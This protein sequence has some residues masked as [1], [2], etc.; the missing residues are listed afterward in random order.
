MSD[1]RRFLVSV[2]VYAGT[3][4]VATAIPVFL[5]PLLTR[6]L[7]PEDYGM[8]GMFLI[9][10]NFATALVGLGLNG[11]LSVRY[12]QE[13]FDFVS[14]VKGCVYLT[15]LMW[16]VMSTL[17]L[18]GAGLVADA[19]NMPSGWVLLAVT[20]GASNALL[21]LRLAI[22]QAA[23][24]P[25]PF[26]LTR[27]AQAALD[28]SMSLLMVL[29]IWQAWQGRVMGIAGALIVIGGFATFSLWR[30]GY[31]RAPT[32]RRALR[33]ALGFGLPLMPHLLG[34][35]A[36]SF[37]D[38]LLIS[39]LLG[40]QTLGIYMVAAQIGLILN[41]I[42]VSVNRAFAPWLMRL[43]VKED[44][45]VDRRIVMVSYAYMGAITVMVALTML[46]SPLLIRL[47]T[48]PTFY[49]AADVLP[50][51]I[52]GTGFTAF[53]YTVTNYMFYANRTGWLSAG[54]VLCAVLSLGLSVLLIL[55]NGIV[56]AGQAF[57]AGQALSFAVTFMLAQ[58]AHPMPWLG[59]RA[60]R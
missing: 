3:S 46:A 20:V 18:L 7:S 24:T 9:Y 32:D 16:L 53:Y 34:G 11:A 10:V 44:A 30:A 1:L 50:W 43:L 36:L 4:A 57:A 48:V 29:V 41:L 37:T 6:I 56:G 58:R 28:V 5:L 23:R 33:D 54:T 21:M 22:W 47:L 38:R 15:A 40:A 19:L 55:A 52:L 35:L 49:G 17:C 25:L 14:Y 31:L 26:G 42:V 27:I 2:M 60:R 13:D 8:V 12:F 51:V 59:G 39:H 45:T